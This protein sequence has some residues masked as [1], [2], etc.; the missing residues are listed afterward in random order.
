MDARTP[1]APIRG[2]GYSLR[3]TSP[4]FADLPALLDEAEGLGVDFVELPAIDAR[5]DERPET[6]MRN[7]PRPFCRR[8][9]YHMGESALGKIVC[10]D[11]VPEN[12]GMYVRRGFEMAPDD[13]TEKPLVTEMVG[14]PA[15]IVA[16]SRRVQEG[17]P[18]GVS[19]SEEFIFKGA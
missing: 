12:E 11:L 5:V 2:V 9:P 3:S 8:R 18:T 16:L 7:H 10:L 13:A 15:V 4:E 6:D 19:L 1:L 14:P 17:K